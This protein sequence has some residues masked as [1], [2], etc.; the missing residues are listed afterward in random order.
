MQ[1]VDLKRELKHLYNPSA[2]EVSVVD[3]PKMNF[4]MVDGEGDPNVSEAYGR[5]VEALYAV[6]YALKFMVKKREA[7][8]D[9]AVM[10]LEGLW[11]ADDMDRFSVQHKEAWKWTMM[12]LQPAEYVTEDLFERAREATAKKKDLPALPKVR[13]RALREG[14]AVQILHRG[15]FAEEGPK[16]EKIHR[17]IEEAGHQRR[18]RH[19]EIYLKDF[20][21]TA[22]ENLRT[23]IRQPFA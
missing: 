8:V 2:K 21:R 14:P 6:S 4:L 10:P 20:R 23:V 22:P 5:A 16:I 17:H 19:H 12:I 3:V 7:G 15:P 18:G 11:W 1:K 9:Y 13:F